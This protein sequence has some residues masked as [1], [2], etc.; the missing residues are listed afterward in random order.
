MSKLPEYPLPGQSVEKTVRD[1]IDYLR[2]T[3]I[4]N[5]QG[6]QMKQSRGGT[7]LSVRRDMRPLIQPLPFSPF[8]PTLGG[9]E[10]EGLLLTMVP[11]YVILRKNKGVDAMAHI[12]PTAI[13]D[14]LEVDIGD[15]FT[16][17]IEEDT[18]GEF[19]TA[20]VVKTSGDW[21]SST[22]PDLDAPSASGGIRHVRLCEIFKDK[23]FPEVKIWSTG[24][25]D[26]FAPSILEN[27]YGSDGE[28]LKEYNAGKWKLRGLVAGSGITITQN[29]DTVEVATSEPYGEGWWG[30]LE[31]AHFTN[32]T[33]STPYDLLQMVVEDGRI[34]SVA[35]QG[36]GE[37]TPTAVS[38]DEA[39]PGFAQFTSFAES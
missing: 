21:P 25:V 13:P 37:T 24:H 4:T 19:S 18:S 17:R 12:L 22:A 2:L 23:D 34:M 36:P 16:L 32:I 29:A 14:E 30:T 10:T 27:I 7:T 35:Y 6:G 26:H 39:T 33:D 20:A 28:I 15:K 38:G 11:G 5:F 3:T 8:Y 1:I 9:N 31:W